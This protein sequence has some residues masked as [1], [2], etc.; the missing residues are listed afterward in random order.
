MEITVFLAISY[1]IKPDLESMGPF[2]CIVFRLN[3]IMYYRPPSI[4]ITIVCLYVKPLSIL[5]T[6]TLGRC[7]RRLLKYRLVKVV[8]SLFVHS[9]DVYQGPTVCQA[10]VRSCRG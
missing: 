4:I 6:K 5:E 2:H 1:K 8:V 10:S 3:L 9:A 7:L